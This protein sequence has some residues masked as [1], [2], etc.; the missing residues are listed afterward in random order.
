MSIE[1]LHRILDEGE[2]AADYGEI[3]SETDWINDGKWQHMEE[4]VKLPFEINEEHQGAT[5]GYYKIYHSRSGSYWSDY[6][7]G[8]PT[9]VEVE[10]Y[11][12]TVTLTKYRKKG[13]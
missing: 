9:I 5:A 8:E 1:F 4:I 12:E 2:E 11:T 6:E 7:Y 3:V 10:P 13:Q